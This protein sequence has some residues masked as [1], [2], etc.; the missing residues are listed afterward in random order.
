MCDLG[1]SRREEE[2]SAAMKGTEAYLDPLYVHSPVYMKACD[3]FSYGLVILQV[4]RGEQD[5]WKAKYLAEKIRGEST[6]AEAAAELVKDFLMPGSAPLQ[7]LQELAY[8]GEA[9]LSM[10]VTCRPLMG[11]SAED[12]ESVVGRLAHIVQSLGDSTKSGRDALVGSK[13]ALG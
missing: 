6:S 13:P 11:C 8:L 3:V 5:P 10:D 4:V 1:I 7:A 9:C 2:I 12:K